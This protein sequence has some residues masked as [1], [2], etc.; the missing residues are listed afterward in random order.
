MKIVFCGGHHNSALL[1]AKELQKKSN[2]IFWLGHKYTMAGD[3]NPGAEYVE[4]TAS[5][6]PFIE[7]QAGKWQPYFKFWRNLA[8][9]PV[10]FIQS[11]FW[12]IKIRP[13]LIVSFGGFLALPVAF[14]GWLLGKK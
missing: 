3:K 12:L 2:R 8:R 4:V 6:I 13:K 11:L 5:G 1:V 7:I 10:G 14:C 9:I